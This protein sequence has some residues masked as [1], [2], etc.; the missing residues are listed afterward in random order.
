MAEKLNLQQAEQA[1]R[2]GRTFDSTT[3]SLRAML[4]D[5]K[6]GL[7]WHGR[8]P[9]EW[10]TKLTELVETVGARYVVYSYG[11]P[12]ALLLVDGRRI[13]PNV[14]YSVT[15]SKHQGIVRYAWAG[16]EVIT[17]LEEV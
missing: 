16:R 2:E 11:T 4:L 13:V 10:A 14:E 15:M 12:I 3:G 7:Y 17:E 5:G 8:L 6:G 9:Q 1:I